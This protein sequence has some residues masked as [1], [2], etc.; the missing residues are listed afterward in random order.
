M[1]HIK[2]YIFLAYD[3]YRVFMMGKKVDPT[4]KQNYEN[5]ETNGLN[6]YKSEQEAEATRK[7]FEKERKIKTNIAR[8]EMKIAEI[9]EEIY[10]FGGK[11]SLVV[12]KK[13]RE[14]KWKQDTIYGPISKGRLNAYPLPG[15]RLIENGYRTFHNKRGRSAFEQAIHLLTEINRQGQSPATIATFKLKTLENA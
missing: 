4:L 15:A 14:E 12:I 3:K 8:L 1:R 10:Q 9:E 6:T 7:E 2:G 5:I 13:I 11:E